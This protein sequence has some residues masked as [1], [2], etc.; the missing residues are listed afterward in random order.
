MKLDLLTSLYVFM[1]DIPYDKLMETE[2]RQWPLCA[3]RCSPR[4]W[5]Q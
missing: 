5:R 3:D 2:R 1:A 4:D